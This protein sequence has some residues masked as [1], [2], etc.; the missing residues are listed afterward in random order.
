MAKKA[1]NGQKTASSGKAFSFI[2]EPSSIPDNLVSPID[3]AHGRFYQQVEVFTKP[4]TRTVQYQICIFQ[5][6]ITS[7]KHTCST[8][9]LL[10]FTAPGKYNSDQLMTSLFQYGNISWN[11]ELLIDM[12]VVRDA[13]AVPVDDRYPENG[14]FY[15]SPDFSLYYPMKVKYTAII[16][17]P[18]GGEP[19]W[20]LP[21]SIRIQ[22]AN[23]TSMLGQTATFNVT[24][25]GTAPLFYQWQRNGS[26]ISGAHSSSYTTPPTTEDDN[27]S[28][29]RVIVTN[30]IGSVT[31]N[32]ANLEVLTVEPPPPSLIK[33]PGFELGKTYWTFYTAAAGP[34]FNAAPPGYEGINA[35]NLAFSS[36][37]TNMQLYQSDVNL[38][39]NT[40][41]RL[42]F[43]GKSTLGHDVRVRLFKQVS[44]YP[45]YGLDYTANL[46][47][48]WSVI[49]TEF[50]TTGFTAN[51]TNGRLQFFF[52]TLAKAGDTYNIDNVVLE[53]VNAKPPEVV[54]NSPNGTNIPVT[55]VISVNFSKPMNQTS[56]QSAFSTSPATKGSFSWGGNNMI[57]TPVNLSY[58]TTYNVTVGTGARDSA[59]I[60][61]LSAYNWSFTTVADTVNPTVIGNTPTGTNEPLTTKITVTFSEAM[62]PASVQSAF[63]TSPATTGSFSWSGNVMTY[64]PGSK[65]NSS[66]TYNVTVGTA[67]TDLAGNN[68]SVPFDWNFITMDE[69]LTPPTVKGNSPTGADVSLSAMISVNFSEAMDKA[70]VQSAFSTSPST[71][72]SFSWSGNNMTYAPVNLSYNTTYN[73]TVGTGAMD[74]AGNNLPVQFNW[75]F[76]TVP[77]RMAPGIIGKS[78]TGSNV[79]IDSQIT[80]TFNES[81]NIT[82]V[83]SALSTS[84]ATTGSFSWNGNTVKYIPASKLGYETNYSVT[85][86]SSA[87]DL[88]GNNMPVH[89][90]QFTTEKPPVKNLILNPG[91]ESGKINWTFYTVLAGPTFNAAPPGYEGINAANL[92]FSR[93]STNMQLYQSGI[94]LEPNTRYR[95]SFA[96]KSTLGHD[97]RV[98]LFKQVSPYPLYGLDYTANLDAAW[99]VFTT[100]FNTTGFTANVTDGRI[101]F[102]F[103]PFAKAG[104]TYNIDNVVLEKAIAAPPAPP[105]VV[106][107]A[108]TGTNV[109]VTASISV[110]FSKPMNQTSVQSAFSTTPAINGSFS[111]SGNNMI[112]TPVNLSY[113]TTYN[114][115]VGTGAMDSDSINMLSA[116][117]WSFTTSRD[118]T[119]P[120]VIGNTPTGNSEPVTTKITVTFSKAMN[121]TSVELAFSTLPA[122]TGSFSWSGN[123]MTY[124]LIRTLNTAGCTS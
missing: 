99:S 14:V 55:A 113:N 83:E 66:R 64:T 3:Y 17:P 101:Q 74:I 24:V 23:L 46:G 90:W 35:A 100:E 4:S 69:D 84:P 112:Y 79:P 37:N 80:V 67:A 41:Y 122:T 96:G 71:N 110:N 119:N 48:N 60:N 117:N 6:N 95:M 93:V 33:N 16:V 115:T 88:A 75:N 72:G 118:T 39:P 116:Y 61:M 54:G 94:K 106:G 85:I 27:G 45:L 57:Y 68:M 52:S 58:N 89:T 49:T 18:G 56:V 114:V 109:L 28:T 5:D 19:V 20:T 104:D 81:M 30:E 2:N 10:K 65:L 92:A 123:V 11:R 121:N 32:N 105:E 50:N 36:V 22:T 12:L 111:W 31:S 42:S 34:T 29:Y 73:V 47:V 124:T 62:N 108:P 26:N 97:V 21:P 38:E 15:G 43:A 77:D 8:S 53:K 78:P 63:S 59:G 103:V 120:D 91:F 40:R 44:P 1:V 25:T 82:S 86:G 13:Y 51:V 76:T 87:K 70:S 102:Y 107:N 98:R 7:D 9:S